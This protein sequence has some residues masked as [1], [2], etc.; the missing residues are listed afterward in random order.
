LDDGSDI[1]VDTAGTTAA[2]VDSTANRWEDR[3]GNNRHARGNAANR[4]PLVVDSVFSGK[5]AVRGM[6][7]DGLTNGLLINGNV[8]GDLT[9]CYV[10]KTTTEGS[11]DRTCVEQYQSGFL[12]GFALKKNTKIPNGWNLAHENDIYRRIQSGVELADNTV[13]QCFFST[14]GSDSMRIWINN[15]PKGSPRPKQDVIANPTNATISVGYRPGSTP[16]DNGIA[17][18]LIMFNRILTA[19]ERHKLY[20]WLQG[21]YGL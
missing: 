5:P 4:A 1:F 11:G 18:S 13:W 2:G 3:S 21:R 10:G 8:S 7:F 9:V 17:V 6:R 14:G 12:T 15:E 16:I 19:D 20:I